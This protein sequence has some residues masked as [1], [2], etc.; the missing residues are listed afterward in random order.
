V[1]QAY[2]K[3]GFEML[4]KAFN[5]PEYLPALTGLNELYNEGEAAMENVDWDEEEDADF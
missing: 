4:L 2:E 1:L 5:D 3:D